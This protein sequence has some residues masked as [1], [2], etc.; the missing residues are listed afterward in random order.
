MKNKSSLVLCI[1]MLFGSLSAMAN[2][3]SEP[4]NSKEV[5]YI[6]QLCPKVDTLAQNIGDKTWYAPG[7][8]RSLN[9]SFFRSVERFL[10]AQWVG[11]T[12]GNVICSYAKADKPEFP[13]HL[14]RDTI[15]ASP[16]GG[17]WTEDKG[18]YKNCNTNDVTLC[19]FSVVMPTKPKNIYEDID[20][21]NK[22]P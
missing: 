8:W 20:Y 13:L 2:S 9:P 22:N 5:T 4:F 3:P 14:Q 1:G 6:P 18:G 7:G 17:S 19:P 10:G 21:Y 15:V 16:T 12:V 11:V